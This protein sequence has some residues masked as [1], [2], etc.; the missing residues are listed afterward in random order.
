MQKLYCPFDVFFDIFTR[1]SRKVGSGPFP[2]DIILRL[3]PE[4]DFI[5]TFGL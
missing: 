3:A 5:D 4:S 2:F 1:N